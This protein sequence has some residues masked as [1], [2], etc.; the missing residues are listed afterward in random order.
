MEK[1]SLLEGAPSDLFPPAYQGPSPS[2]PND[3][4]VKHVRDRWKEIKF[5]SDRRENTYPLFKL[6]KMAGVIK[7]L[8]NEGVPNAHMQEA[9]IL[10]V[11]LA[12]NGKDRAQWV[13]GDDCQGHWNT[14]S[15]IAE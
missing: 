5:Q 6:F 7:Q 4:I 14:S 10:L 9:T 12:Y 1:A 11:L 2:S 15:E 13:M 3:N 8:N